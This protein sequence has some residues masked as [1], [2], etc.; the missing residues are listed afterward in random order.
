[1]RRRSMRKAGFWV[2]GY[3]YL[4]ADLPMR[5]SSVDLALSRPQVGYALRSSAAP[6]AP[7][8]FSPAV[9]LATRA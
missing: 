4:Q 3:R 9:V 8:R 5:G 6:S 2:L 7:L 1:M